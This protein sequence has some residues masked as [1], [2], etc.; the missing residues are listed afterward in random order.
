M[1]NVT[2]P[3]LPP[4]EKLNG[5]L[6]KIYASNQITNNGQFV[7]LLEKKIAQTLDVK[8]AILVS[9]GSLGL[10]IA[11]KALDLK[12]EVITSP[13]SFI[14]TASTLFWDN[15]QPI[16]VDINDDNWNI[17][18]ERIPEKITK[19][20]SA[21]LPVHVF[22]NPCDVKAIDEIAQKNNL[23][24]IYDAAHAFGAK[25]DDISLPSFGDISVISL[26]ATKIFHSIEG[27]AI[28]TNQ[29]NIAKKIRKIINFGLDSN[30]IICE[31]GTNAKMSEFNAAM[32]LCVLDDFD[33]I[34]NS[35][36][37]I[38]ENYLNN[39]THFLKPQLWSQSS[40]NNFSYAP[41]TFPDEKTLDKVLKKLNHKNIFPR[42]Y[43][44]PSLDSVSYL[45]TSKRNPKSNKISRT[46]L[47]LPIYPGLSESDQGKVIDTIN[48]NI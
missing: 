46:I 44:Y 34:K 48:K 23:K 2:K 11:Y 28:I 6:K 32:G 30:N 27:G 13:F 17:D 36:K 5:Y 12:G 43:F 18:V 3:Y 1:I 19:K 10:H 47:C 33:Y 29:D 31:P 38:Y 35:R 15:L 26:H 4:L 45:K 41:F 14:A 7:Q 9:N 20:T 42:R 37:I 24:V 40:K 21:I 25:L 22:G 16:F 8:H 39:L